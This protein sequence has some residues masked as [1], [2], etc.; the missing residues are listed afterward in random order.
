MRSLPCVACFG[1]G[2]GFMQRDT[3]QF[4]FLFFAWVRI[5]V[6]FCWLS[7]ASGGDSVVF[8]VFLVM[9]EVLVF[10]LLVAG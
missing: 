5:D 2:F 8:V 9:V 6:F 4:Q 3:S 1:V 10:L 7:S